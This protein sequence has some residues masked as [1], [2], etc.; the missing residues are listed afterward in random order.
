MNAED[1]VKRVRV[2]DFMVGDPFTV[3]PETEIR[4]VVQLL[5]EHDLSGALVTDEAGD[6]VGVITERDCIA[7]AAEAG[8]YGH[9]GGPV[10]RFMSSPVESVTASDSLVDVATRMV[11]SPY[12]RFPVIDDGRLVGLI[13]RREVLRAINGE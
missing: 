10:S 1:P 13:S 3:S 6:V 2:G 8:Y 7:V 9:W 12:R 5:I 11:Q 4:R